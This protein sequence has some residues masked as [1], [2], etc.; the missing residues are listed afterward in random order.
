MSK[1]TPRGKYAENLKAIEQGLAATH[2][3]PLIYP[4][5]GFGLRYEGKALDLA[6]DAWL[7][8][9][10]SA[11]RSKPVAGAAEPEPAVIVWP[12]LRKRASSGE[13]AYVFARL[14][15]HIVMSHLD[16]A[17]TGLPWHLSCWY[18]AEGLA[19]MA[20]AGSRPADFPPLPAEIPKGSEE[21]LAQYFMETPSPPALEALSLGRPGE[22]FW[23]FADGFTITDRLRAE[24]TA[25]LA[26]GIRAAASDAISAA[27]GVSRPLGGRD[28]GSNAK[29]AREWVISEYPLLGS[30]AASF[31]LIEDMELCRTMGVEVAAICDATQEIYINPRSALTQE[32]ARF[33]LAHEFLHAGL[34]HT[35]RCQG[36]D[37]WYWNVACDYVINGWLIEMQTACPPERLGYLY[38]AALKD[39]S[40]EEVY[41]RI[42]RDVRWMRKLKKARTMNGADH[43]MIEGGRAPGWWRGGGIDL[44]TFYRRA[45][46]QG[47]ELHLGS[48]RGFLPAGLVEEIRSLMQPPVPWDVKLAHWLDQFF[49]PL[50]RRR[51]Y[52]RAHRRQ[53][54]TPAIPRPAWI[55][56][57][58]E[59]ASRVFGAV[60]DTSGSMSRA[61]LGKAIG[62]IAGYAI[63]RDV[64]LVRLIQCDAAP[65]DCGYVEPE[66]LLDRVQVKG[67]GGTVL[68]RGIVLL[69][70]AQDFPKDGPILIITDG[71]CDSLAVRREHAY[72]LADGG[73]LPFAPRGPVFS[74]T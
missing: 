59:R 57:N 9:E 64:R 49:P 27:G 46:A 35:Q 67:R 54:A 38:D 44:D 63:S 1:K 50:E 30:L 56:P 41:D 32:E 4:L 70:E 31:T 7:A 66:A 58:E 61:S 23:G 39:M 20:G 3:H 47:L 36:R 51:S 22:P 19:L 8:A 42:V 68:M 69:E 40:A 11:P 53:S 37:P 10:C 28:A 62:A 33:V 43:D 73:R 65:Y 18:H 12:N 25:R 2:A 71:A 29:R 74:V 52:A 72:L 45:L 60:V 5:P 17:R 24:R 48:G 15:L 26:T 14:R 21:Q 55:A 13:W 6:S 16:P 34:R